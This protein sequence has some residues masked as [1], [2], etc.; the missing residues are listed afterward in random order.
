MKG[1]NRLA[2]DLGDDGS[3]SLEGKDV[4][5]KKVANLSRNRC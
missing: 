2:Y 3:P 4:V 5:E 1:E